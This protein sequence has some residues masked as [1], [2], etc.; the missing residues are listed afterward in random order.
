MDERNAGPV[1]DYGEQPQDRDLTPL[2]GAHQEL[3]EAQGAVRHQV[4]ELAMKL[5][6][7]LRNP[8]EP[9]NMAK[10]AEKTTDRVGPIQSIAVT[11]V[12]EQVRKERETSDILSYIN[13]NLEV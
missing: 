5:R 8:Y 13:K 11:K 10:A 1:R 6:T 7:V 9:E 12:Y 3:A 4:E 2:D